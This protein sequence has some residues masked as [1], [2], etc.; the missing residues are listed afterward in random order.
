MGPSDITPSGLERLDYLGAVLGVFV[1]L[2]RFAEGFHSLIFC[3]PLDYVGDIEIAWSHDIQNGAEDQVL[4]PVI[5]TSYANED[6]ILD[7]HEILEY[8]K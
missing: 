2:F 1:V 7:I 3:S 5:V 4:F 6:S 8:S